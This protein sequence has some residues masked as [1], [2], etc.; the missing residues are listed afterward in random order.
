MDA[1][2]YSHSA[3]QAQRIEKFIE[4]PDST[5]GV[6]T[7]PS[8]IATG[9][10]VTVPAGR[11]A[12]LANTQ[13]NGTLVIDGDVFIP[14]GATFDDLEVQIA[15]KVSKVTSTDNSIVRFNGTTGD[16]QNSSVSVDDG[17]ILK[18]L[19]NIQAGSFDGGNSF[20]YIQKQTVQSI[21]PVFQAFVGGVITSTIS[22]NGNLALGSASMSGSRLLKV[23]SGTLSNAQSV[24]VEVN[25]GTAGVTN[26]Y[27][28][29]GI[30][31]HST[32]VNACGYIN[33]YSQ[34]GAYSF[35]WSD[36]VDQLRISAAASHIGTTSGTIVGTQTSDERVKNIVGTCPYG[37][38]EILELETY[39]YSMKDDAEGSYKLGFVAQQAMGVIPESVYDTGE[40]L[41]KPVAVT[42]YKVTQEAIKDED[43]NILEPEITEPYEDIEYQETEDTVTKL[44][45]DYQMMIP[46]LVNAM[47]EQQELINSLKARLDILEGAV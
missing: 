47:K 1:V 45:M 3:K 9:E 39:K 43:G 15:S 25:G 41:T 34:D 24:S 11:T 8:I 21:D 36:D 2:S 44:A 46:V 20:T 38:Q 32:L 18:T 40:R 26:R 29:I 7:Q 28:G 6:L 10:T 42:K 23:E 17:G 30:Y 37:L 16:V 35:I 5:S 22:A 14:S 19:G 31:K 27:A 33:L 12:I 4:N 13:I